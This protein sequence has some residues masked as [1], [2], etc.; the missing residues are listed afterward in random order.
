M[1]LRAIVLKGASIEAFWQPM[2]ALGVF[3]VV[4]LG[5]ASIRLGREWS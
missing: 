3:A 2:A 5:L 1:A 4:V